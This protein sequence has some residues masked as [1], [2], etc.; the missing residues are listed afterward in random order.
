MLTAVTSASPHPV[1]RRAYHARLVAALVR[2]TKITDAARE[3]HLSAKTVARW[4]Q[5]PDWRAEV[6][7]GRAQ[8]VREAFEQLR[9]TLP[10]AAERLVR[11]V[12]NAKNDQEGA[13]A[14]AALV[15]AFRTL[16]ARAELER[17]R[18]AEEQAAALQLHQHQGRSGRGGSLFL[19]EAA[20]Y[21]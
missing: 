12:R 5:N 21:Q 20:A 18:A 3:A 13:I 1:R 2:H 14:A 10:A 17:D 11:A 16:A 4:L 9:G 15:E 6:Q 19:G 8:P 7:A